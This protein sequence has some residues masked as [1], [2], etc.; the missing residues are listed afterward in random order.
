M[1]YGIERVMDKVEL[2]LDPLEVIRKNPSQ[3]GYFTAMREHFWT[4][5]FISKAVELG[6]RE[7][8]PC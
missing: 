1:Y 6:G 8:A 5:V 3:Q 7:R 4:L 2:G